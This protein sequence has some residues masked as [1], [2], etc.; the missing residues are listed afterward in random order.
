V[1]TNLANTLEL[2]NSNLGPG[3]DVGV[4]HFL[5]EMGLDK[6][7]SIYQRGQTKFELPIGIIANAKF[8]EKI[9][10]AGDR[11]ILK[12]EV[13]KKCDEL[14]RKSNKSVVWVE[15]SG[16]VDLGRTAKAKI[17]VGAYAT[18]QSAFEFSGQLRM[19]RLEPYESPSGVLPKG[20]SFGHA[21]GV[22]YTAFLARTMPPGGEFEI[23]GEGRLNLTF[24]VQ[25]ALK[26]TGKKIATMAMEV[27]VAAKVICLAPTCAAW[28]L[29]IPFS[30]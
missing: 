26:A 3:L 18:A 6:L 12:D 16:L 24:E 22:P 4:S 29:P 13:R 25:A 28:T 19:R 8:A 17:P 7:E 2:F 27:A 23:S 21:I 20:V 15:T 9:I 14:Y 5:K 10:P 30:L 1:H 11:E